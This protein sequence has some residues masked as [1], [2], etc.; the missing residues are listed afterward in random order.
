MKIVATIARYL[1][2][3]MF[4][5]FGSNAFLHFI[6]TGPLPP[7]TFGQFASV[8]AATGYV[9]VVGFF[10]VVPAILLLINRY[11][12]LALTLLGPVIFNILVV[13]VLMAPSSIGPGVFAA[14][15]WFLVFWRV[16]PA[17]RGIFWAKVED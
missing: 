10:Q 14:V 16:F 4:L 8:L 6:P 15:C 3:L 12:P 7:G 2:G 5:I 17:F 9:Y 1:L 11:V 13:H